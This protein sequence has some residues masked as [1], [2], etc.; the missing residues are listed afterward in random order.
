MMA[1]PQIISYEEWLA[2]PETNLPYEII[3]GEVIRYPAPTAL[4]Q[5]IVGSVVVS[6]S[7]FV[8]QSKLGAVLLAPIDLVIRRRPLRT[9]QPDILYIS[10]ERSGKTLADLRAMPVL[11]LPLDL[12]VEVLAHDH[13][14]AEVMPKVA[15]YIVNGVRECWLVSPEAET[16]EVLRLTAARA[17]RIHLFGMGDTLRSEVISGFNMKV[18]EIFD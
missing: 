8:R 6:L 3:D 2:T 16:V 12:V 11:E 14:R 9:R 1:K 18:D 15:D 4:H 13:S 7:R 17:T 5:L 10:F